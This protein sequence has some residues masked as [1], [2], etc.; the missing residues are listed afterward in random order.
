M[1]HMIKKGHNANDPY[2]LSWARHCQAHDAEERLTANFGQIR[3]PDCCSVDL[4]PH[5]VA[6]RNT[7][8]FTVLS[9]HANLD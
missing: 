9:T 7:I 6:N 1:L 2:C 3:C 8:L 4:I 5:T